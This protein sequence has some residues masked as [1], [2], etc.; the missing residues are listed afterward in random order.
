M[1]SYMG[2]VG[3]PALPVLFRNRVGGWAEGNYIYWRIDLVSCWKVYCLE[4]K[5]CFSAADG[6]VRECSE[7]EY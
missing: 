7:C 1:F 3:V 4:A 6:Y 5:R 2:R